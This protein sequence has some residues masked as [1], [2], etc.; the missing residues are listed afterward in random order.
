MTGPTGPVGEAAGLRGMERDDG[1]DPRSRGIPLAQRGDHRIWAG[2]ARQDH[3]SSSPPDD[4][5]QTA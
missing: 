5:A 2:A 4:A 1:L 3:L